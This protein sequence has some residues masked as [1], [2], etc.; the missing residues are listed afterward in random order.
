MQNMRLL[1]ICSYPAQIKFKLLTTNPEVN[2]SESVLPVSPSTDFFPF[3][4]NL[5]LRLLNCKTLGKCQE[6]ATEILG[7]SWALWVQSEM[8]AL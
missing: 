6:P 3:N 7:L 5:W 2:F 8:R 4:K 1:G